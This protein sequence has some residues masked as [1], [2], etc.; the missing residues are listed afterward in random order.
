M[1]TQS[2]PTLYDGPP[3][4]VQAKW[5]QRIDHC[6]ADINRFS[7]KFRRFFGSA[8]GLAATQGTNCRPSG[9]VSDKG[10]AGAER[11][12]GRLRLMPTTATLIGYIASGLVLLDWLPPVLSLNLLLLPLNAVRLMRMSKPAPATG[13]R[14]RKVS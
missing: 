1:A 8:S 3:S 9:A 11:C 5:T 10:S 7:E 6:A 4:C 13:H 12:P 2:S 14:K